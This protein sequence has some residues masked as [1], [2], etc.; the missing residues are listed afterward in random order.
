MN[1]IFMKR[2]GRVTGSDL[3]QGC[4]ES[5]RNTL[6]TLSDG[7]NMNKISIGNN[8]AKIKELTA[9]NEYLATEVVSAEVLSR[10]IKNLLE[11]TNEH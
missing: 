3:I 10:N 1:L 5:F 8:E 4:F 7:V 11:G 6:V 9:K 2:K